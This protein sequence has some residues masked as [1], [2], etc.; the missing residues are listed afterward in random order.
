MGIKR[1]QKA[2]EEEKMAE[3]REPIKQILMEVMD[4]SWQKGVRFMPPDREFRLKS[5]E[6]LDRLEA[7]LKND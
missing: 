7:L 4:A 1:T 2:K 5:Q 3:L 6:W